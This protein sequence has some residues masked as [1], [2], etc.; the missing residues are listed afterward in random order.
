[1][2]AFSAQPSICLLRAVVCFN[3]RMLSSLGHMQIRVL[4]HITAAELLPF[5][6]KHV[7]PPNSALNPAYFKKVPL[8]F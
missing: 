2:S 4:G 3:P 7:V 8:C 1:M 5:R 6:L